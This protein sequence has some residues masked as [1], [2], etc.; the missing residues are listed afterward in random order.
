MSQAMTLFQLLWW[1]ANA[2]NINLTIL[3][4]WCIFFTE[5][6]PTISIKMLLK[7][8]YVVKH[9]TVKHEMVSTIIMVNCFGNASCLYASVLV[10]E[11]YICWK[12]HQVNLRHVCFPFFSWPQVTAIFWNVDKMVSTPGMLAGDK[13]TWYCIFIFLPPITK[14]IKNPAH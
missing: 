11:L 6:L 2:Q 8:L 4:E 13:V 1:W 10:F 14:L 5:M 12:H 3:L 9:E 7:L